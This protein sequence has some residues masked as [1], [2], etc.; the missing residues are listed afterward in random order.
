PPVEFNFENPTESFSPSPI[1]IEDSDSLMKEIDIFL[2]DDDSIPSGI[3]SDNFDLEDDDNSTSHPEFE[4]FHVD[5]PDSGDSTIDV[6]EDNT[7][8]L[9]FFNCCLLVLKTLKA[10]ETMA[11][12]S[13]QY[14]FKKTDPKSIVLAASMRVLGTG[15]SLKDKN[16]AKPDKTEHGIGKSAKNQGQRVR[17][18]LLGDQDGL[19][20]KIGALFTLTQQ[21]QQT[22]D[23]SL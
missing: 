8:N 22:Q 5:Y 1:P 20:V 6:V 11:T 13:V 9:G 14:C 7:P 17:I 12:T 15:Y 2:D 4:S 21:T 10:L 23:G 3:E 18:S 19:R 16:E